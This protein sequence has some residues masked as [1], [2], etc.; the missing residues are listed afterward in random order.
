[1]ITERA[2]GPDHPLAAKSLSSLALVYGDR[3][4]ARAGGALLERSLAITEKALGPDHF[5]VA[6]TLDVLAALYRATGREDEAAELFEAR[7][8]RIRAI[9]R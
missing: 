6:G 7:A 4:P 8:A 9:R 1:M 3:E 5:A 2:F